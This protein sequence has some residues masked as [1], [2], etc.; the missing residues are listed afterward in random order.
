MI[1]CTCFPHKASTISCASSIRSFVVIPWCTLERGDCQAPIIDSEGLEMEGILVDER[2]ARLLELLEL[3]L[4][5]ELELLLLLLLELD[6]RVI[7]SYEALSSELLLLLLVGLSTFM[8]ALGTYCLIFVKMDSSFL[9]KLPYVR[10]LSKG[11]RC[12]F[13]RIC[14]KC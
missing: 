11:C 14:C 8:Y 10:L 13:V 7:P 9:R 12:I 1:A 6:G 4:E 3:E 2:R 5:L